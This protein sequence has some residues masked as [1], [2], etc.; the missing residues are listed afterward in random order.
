[1]LRRARFE[2]VPAYY[3]HHIDTVRP[4]VPPVPREH[5]SKRHEAREDR[6]MP[7]WQVQLWAGTHAV[8]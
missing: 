7:A 5:D 3:W 8:G 6:A 4:N 1:M 2:D